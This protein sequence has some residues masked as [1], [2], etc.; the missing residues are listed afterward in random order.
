M[1]IN[2]SYFPK[3]HAAAARPNAPAIE[4]QVP[5]DAIRAISGALRPNPTKHLT[6]KYGSA[7]VSTETG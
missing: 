5:I 3:T 7:C 1:N 2:V 4:A 6:M